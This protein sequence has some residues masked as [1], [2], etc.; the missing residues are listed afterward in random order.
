L[1]SVACRAAL[2]IPRAFCAEVTPVDGL[3]LTVEL[4]P[5]A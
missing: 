4:L 1:S 3:T 2:T 5:P